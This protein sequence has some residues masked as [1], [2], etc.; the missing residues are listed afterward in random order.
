MKDADHSPW[1]VHARNELISLCPQDRPA[2]VYS[3]EQ[4]SRNAGA[5]ASLTAIDRIFYAIKANSNPDLLRHIHAT[6]AGLECVSLGE[7][8][9]VKSAV[10]AVRTDQLLFT[11]NFAPR[12]EYEA[13]VAIGVILTIDSLYPLENWPELFKGQN[14]ILRVNSGIK[15]GHHRHV[16]TAGPGSKF[17]L[18]LEDMDA[19]VE[20]AAA[21]GANVI[22]LHAH[23][24]SGITDDTYWRRN[25]CVLADLAQ[26]IPSVRILNLGGG[27]AVNDPNTPDPINLSALNQQLEQEQNRFANYQLWLEPGRFFVANAGVLLARITQIKP[28]SDTVFIGL[29]AGMNT[30]IR[31]A[32]YGAQHSIFNLT[33]LN[34]PK[35]V[36]GTIVGPICESADRFANQIP[37][38]ASQ[39]GDVVLIAN[40]GAYGQVMSSLYNSRPPAHEILI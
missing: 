8:E 23:A 12:L 25:G 38:P 39:E 33:R 27:L 30:F 6:G 17:G 40:A 28:A 7:L 1:W 31:P 21:I 29:N 10:P 18:S 14:I 13:A 22:G 20:L 15:A 26:H 35:D 11:P 3:R 5:L 19:A 9:A 16:Q 24:G 32:L 4:I 37:F 2:Y 34:A 36:T